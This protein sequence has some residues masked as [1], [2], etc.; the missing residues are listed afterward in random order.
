M[1]RRRLLILGGTSEARALAAR[2]VADLGQRI[3]VETS[4]AGRTADPLTPAGRV[5]SGGFGG[6]EAMAD[7]LSDRA[8][9]FLIDATHPYAAAIS[10]NAERAASRAGVPR[11]VLTRPAWRPGPGDRWHAVAD[12]DAAASA[13]PALGTCAL[14][15]T[16][17]RSLPVFGRVRDVRVIARMISAPEVVPDHPDLTILIDRGPF[18]LAGERALFSRQGIN[19]LVT[20]NSG[21]AETAAKLDAARERGLPIVVID[22]PD[23]PGGTAVES[24]DAAVAWLSDQ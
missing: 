22:R 20:K 15:T 1:T 18:D 13:L 12:E 17:G 16:G 9:D 7:Y 8:I 6:A 14:V 11:L 19:I 10:R 21:G 4:L 5:R 24:V 3:D 23:P 2:V